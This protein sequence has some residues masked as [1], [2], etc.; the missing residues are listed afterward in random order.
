VL[1]VAQNIPY[2][3]FNA[4]TLHERAIARVQKGLHGIGGLRRIELDIIK[5]AVTVGALEKVGVGPGGA[6]GAVADKL[7]KNFGFKCECLLTLWGGKEVTLSAC[8]RV[9]LL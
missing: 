3:V 4:C 1:A 6:Q 9:Y 8:P 5:R 7:A 2:L